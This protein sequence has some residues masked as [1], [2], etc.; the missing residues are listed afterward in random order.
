M[1]ARVAEASRERVAVVAIVDR[2]A[3]GVDFFAARGDSCR[4]EGEGRE[5]MQAEQGEWE[6]AQVWTGV[7][8]LCH[9][10]ALPCPLDAVVR[11]VV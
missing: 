2:L 10:T 3:Q 4:L 8:S 6:V 1:S 9:A 11:R 7:G 5:V